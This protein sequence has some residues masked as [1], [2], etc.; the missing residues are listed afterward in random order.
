MSSV[1]SK[2]VSLE[3]IWKKKLTLKH[4]RVHIEIPANSRYE[5]TPDGNMVKK[6][7]NKYAGIYEIVRFHL[8]E[9]VNTFFLVD[10]KGK[11]PLYLTF[12][13]IREPDGTTQKWVNLKKASHGGPYGSNVLSSVGYFKEEDMIDDEPTEVDIE[14]KKAVIAELSEFI[15]G[16]RSHPPGV[17]NLYFSGKDYPEIA[18][19]FRKKQH[20]Q[21]LTKKTKPPSRRKSIGGRRTRRRKKSTK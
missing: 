14:N 20:Q 15:H 21:F 18:K 4:R 19:S 17:S 8:Y 16:V 3:N 9:N 12:D 11:N 6:D 7:D 13:E 10:T 1:K 5:K 2:S